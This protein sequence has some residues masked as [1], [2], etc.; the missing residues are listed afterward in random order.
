MDRYG[1]IVGKSRVMSVYAESPEE[2][3]E[4]AEH[5]LDKPGR[6]GILRGWK[7]GGERVE[8]VPT[9]GRGVQFKIKTEDDIGTPW[10]ALSVTVAELCENE[11]AAYARAAGLAQRPGVY[12]VRWNWAGSLQGHYVPGTKR[13]V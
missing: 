7:D 2:A 11:G 1:V 9:G 6:R 10:K 5:Q 3:R 13:Q 4:K 12:E 8:L